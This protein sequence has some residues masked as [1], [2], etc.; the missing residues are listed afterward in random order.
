MVKYPE[1]EYCKN[2]LNEENLDLE[3]IKQYIDIFIELIQ[4]A[5]TEINALEKIK[6]YMTNAKENLERESRK[7]NQNII[8]LDIGT[9]KLDTHSNYTYKETLYNGQTIYEFDL[10]SLP[11]GSYTFRN[12][13]YYFTLNIVLDYR[14]QRITCEYNCE[15]KNTKITSIANK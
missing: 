6:I 13:N 14:K 10:N 7:R 12:N 1:E 8:F 2:I 3:R 4:T 11:D 9:K 15:S 5:N